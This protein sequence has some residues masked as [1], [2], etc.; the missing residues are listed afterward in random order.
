MLQI[1]CKAPAVIFNFKIQ[2]PADTK[3]KFKIQYLGQMPRRTGLFRGLISE[4]TSVIM[5]VGAQV[6]VD[7]YLL[8]PP[9]FQA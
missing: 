9:T 8:Q 7:A 3:T 2:I 1:L 6:F 5:V 4:G